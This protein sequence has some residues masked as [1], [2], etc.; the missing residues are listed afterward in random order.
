M[1]RAVV[2]ASAMRTLIVVNHPGQVAT[3][4]AG[5]SISFVGGGLALGTEGAAI[6]GGSV[7]DI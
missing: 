3:V 1:R 6:G 2:L 7:P 5:C 4:P